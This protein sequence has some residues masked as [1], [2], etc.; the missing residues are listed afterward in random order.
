MRAPCIDMHNIETISQM[1]NLYQL[2]L[3]QS[4]TRER[5]AVQV[6]PQANQKALADYT[7]QS[8]LFL[9]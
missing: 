5:A 9:S 1:Q 3:E 7:V 2:E 6:K 8:L 4:M